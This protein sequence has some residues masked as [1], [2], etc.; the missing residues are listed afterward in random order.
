[1][2]AEQLAGSQSGRAGDEP[3]A[4]LVAY[5][6]SAEWGVEIQK[7]RVVKARLDRWSSIGLDKL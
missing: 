2:G 7:W 3:K 5:S 1:M 4:V 6:V